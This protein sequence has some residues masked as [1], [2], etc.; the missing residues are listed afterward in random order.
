MKK[1]QIYYYILHLLAGISIGFLL[2]SCKSSKSNC[3]AYSYVEGYKYCIEGKTVVDGDTVD[4]VAF[5]NSY[6]MACDSIFYYNSDSSIQSLLQPY[7][8]KEIY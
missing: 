8:V 7:I 5:T 4:A 3:D 1:E 2:F 6:S